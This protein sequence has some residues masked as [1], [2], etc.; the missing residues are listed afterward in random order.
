MTAP[1]HENVPLAYTL[2]LGDNALVLGQRLIERVTHEPELEEELATANIALDYIG[3]ARLYYSYAGEL[4]GAGRDEDD[5]AYLR[6]E[7]EFQNFLLVEQPDGHFGDAIVR[8]VFFQTFY[9]LQLEALCAAREQRLAEIA[10]RAVN[11]VRYHARNSGRWFVRLGD[12]TEESHGKMQQSVDAHWRY[13]GEL[14]A[15][16]A[17]DARFKDEWN[18]P[19]LRSIETE[20]RARMTSLF[21]EATLKQ[22]ADEWLPS[23]GREGR[24]S[25]SFGYLLLELQSLKRAHPDA[26]W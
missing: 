19:D 17:I 11:E 23:S 24:H 7:H 16:D 4:E 18:G 10:A 26:R 12:G 9:L 22:P 3:Q 5:F 14:F 20:W 1:R 15:G 2:R 6:D 21:T 25:E 8:Q 13:V